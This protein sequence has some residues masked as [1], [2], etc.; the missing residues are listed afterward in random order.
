MSVCMHA[1]TRVYMC[2]CRSNP[3]EDRH[4]QGNLYNND[5]S[6]AV[7][8]LLL[9]TLHRRAA[10][11]ECLE[12]QTKSPICHRTLLLSFKKSGGQVLLQTPAWKLR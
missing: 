1:C 3:Y 7:A 6:Y 8:Q 5:G 4:T 10:A 12:L 9:Q 11:G 2:V